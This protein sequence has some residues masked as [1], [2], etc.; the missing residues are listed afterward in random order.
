MPS[1]KALAWVAGVLVAAVVL[2][3]IFRVVQPFQR[4]ADPKPEDVAT[5]WNDSIA[6]LGILPVYPP[7]EDLYVGDV[8]AV[9]AHSE[10][11][12]LLGKA[13]RVGHIDLRREILQSAA[14]AIF[15]DTAELAAGSKLR[16]QDPKE[17]APGAPDNRIA[18]S[19]AA[20]PG[21]TITHG[22]K[23][24]GAAGVS[25]SGWFGAQ[26]DDSSIEQISIKSVE[27]YGVS[28]VDGV[29]KLDAWCSAAENKRY[30]ADGS[31]RRILAFTVSD[32]V[33]G[34]KNGEYTSRI[35][36]RLV[37]RVFL[38][39]EIEHRRA[40]NSAAGGVLQVLADPLKEAATVQDGAPKPEAPGRAAEEAAA[41]VGRNLA[42]SGATGAK[43][44]L[45]H[46]DGTEM[47]LQE[48]FQRPLAF[49]FRAVTIA[50]KPSKPSAGTVP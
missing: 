23:S 41:G 24:T 16:K 17:A 4:Q 48:V 49:G 29:L 9:I 14:P 26:R 44:A 35:E 5:A 32:K 31:V 18:L 15:S 22:V 38:M 42:G 2:F 27:T 30:C 6:K 47:R 37:T 46:S 19:L 33:L 13:V 39:R 40:L 45:L 12:P 21:I 36:L 25:G 8:W 20:F 50:L 34:T 43:I 10:D 7:A 28:P 1:R 3:F 11:S